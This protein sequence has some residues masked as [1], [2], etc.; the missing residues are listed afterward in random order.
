MW[1]QKKEMKIGRM[2]RE[3]KI[4]LQ[5]KNGERKKKERKKLEPWAW[6]VKNCCITIY[7]VINSLAARRRPSPNPN[8]NTYL[9]E[10]VKLSFQHPSIHPSRCT[11]TNSDSTHVQT[12]GT[13]DCEYL[14]LC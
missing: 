5:K 9:F 1:S 10:D 11:R 14:V 6:E 12:H 3:G 7:E 8:N 13:A 4:K 2:A